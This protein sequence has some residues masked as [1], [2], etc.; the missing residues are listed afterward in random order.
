M[1][2]SD[3]AALHPSPPPA[4]LGL[5]RPGPPSEPV[6]LRVFP[7]ATFPRGC[8]PCVPLAPT[9]TVAARAGKAPTETAHRTTHTCGVWTSP[10]TSGRLHASRPLPRRNTRAFVCETV[11]S[12]EDEDEDGGEEKRC[13]C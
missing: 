13:V 9:R 8:Q 5:S 12:R 4:C 10:L 3:L 7:G 2:S 11:Y 6:L 1:C